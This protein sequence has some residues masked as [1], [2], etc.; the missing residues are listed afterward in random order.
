MSGPSFAE[1]ITRL[2]S[3]MADVANGDAEAIKA[4]YSHGDDVTSFYG[5]GG[6]ER[7]W[8]AVRAGIAT[9]DAIEAEWAGRVGARRAAALRKALEI[10]TLD[11]D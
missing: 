3:A 7:G 10:I 5:W 9:V 2:R 11:E 8:E 1:A 6:Y 4:L